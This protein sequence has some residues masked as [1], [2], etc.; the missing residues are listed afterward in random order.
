MGEIILKVENLTKRFKGLVALDHVSFSVERGMILGIIGPNGAG[1][2]TLFKCITSVYK[3]TEGKVY[4]KGE[5][6]TDLPTYKKARLGI[7]R[8]HQI[9]RPLKDLTVLKN[10][11]VGACFGK[12]S[13]SLKESEQIAEEI[14]KF[15]KLY[16]K[17]DV[18]AGKL[19]VPQKKRLELARALAGEPELL[20]LDEVLAGL[21]PG[22][23]KE[24]LEIIKEIRRQGITILMIE[25]LMHAIMNISDR[26]VVLDYGKK[27]AEGSPEEVANDPK[28]IEAY[29]GD[30]E[31]ALKLLKEK[32]DV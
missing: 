19:N 17:K 30:P 22:E 29:L 23:V 1:K 20:L 5:D 16:D 9:V 7:A 3:P 28:V 32:R 21:T 15:V 31:A 2:T 14:L 13:A 11:M 12:K 27:I 8:T 26:I 10:V 4:F 25:H 18:E 6:V 24:M